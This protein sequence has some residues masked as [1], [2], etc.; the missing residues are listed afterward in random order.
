MESFE[1]GHTS[2]WSRVVV[3]VVFFS[4]GTSMP[5]DEDVDEGGFR[6]EMSSPTDGSILKTMNIQNRNSP[7]IAQTINR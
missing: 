6:V 7:A 4:L 3:M 5:C 1:E 2:R